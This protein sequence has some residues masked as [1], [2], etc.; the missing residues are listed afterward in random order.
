[1]AGEARAGAPPAGGAGN[2]LAGRLE[3]LTPAQ[4]A[5]LARRLGQR[6][7]PGPYRLSATQFGIWLFEQLNP[8]TSTYHNPAAVRLSGLV[9]EDLLREALQRVQDRHEPLRS[10]YPAD[11]D[12]VPRAFV[13]PPGALRLPWR[14]V[15]V[16]DL[17]DPGREA[18]R[19]VREEAVTPFRLDRGPV[20]RCLLVRTGPDER[21][22]VATFHHIVSDGGSLGVLLA[23]LGA[24]YPALVSGER[25][26]PAVPPKGYFALAAKDAVAPGALEHWLGTLDG[27]PDRID[28]S[29]LAE[30]PGQCEKPQ[31]YA[32]TGEFVS[33]DQIGQTERPG[34]SQVA[35]AGR[36]WAGREMTLRV[37]GST[38]AA[39]EHLCS[40]RS[41]SLFAGLVAASAATLH[42]ASGQGDLVLTTPVDRRDR[43][44]LALI[45]CF[46][47][48]VVLRL[49]VCP[50]DRLDA[51]LERAAGVVADAL[52]HSDLPF[53]RLVSALPRRGDGRS[54]FGNVA[55]VHNNAPLDTVSLGNLR[56][57]HHPLPPVEVKHDLALS[58]N[59]RRDEL[60]GRIEY[61]AR[62][63]DAAVEGLARHLRYTVEML[64]TAPATRVAD[65]SPL[66]PLSEPAG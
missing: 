56:L 2:D 20:W 65:L 31:P 8:G 54:P 35:A 45:G 19:I 1:M 37:P 30:W 28:L 32:S 21:V 12:G 47:N 24:L 3:R 29:A 4:R 52:A 15:D 58:W 50:D 16:G 14:L 33:A 44:G 34:Q 39:L 38:A 25:P 13:E 7:S 64:A 46:V 27:A 42:R 66:S 11:E 5:L 22:L 18:A 53:S 51:L 9:E 48:T 10:R 41:A 62:F 26:A 55:V 61:A 6:A 43:E 63:P 23:E 36:K 40:R 49:R 57:S 60:T 17:P 59:R